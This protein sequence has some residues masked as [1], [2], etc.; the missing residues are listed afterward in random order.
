MDRANI[1]H[2]NFLARVAARDLP[3][4]RPPAGPMAPE[5]ALQ[6]FRAGVLTRALD[7][8]SRAMQRAGPVSYTHLEVYKRQVWLFGLHAV[9]DALLN[10][11]REKLRLVVTRNALDKLE[12]AVAFAGIA[13]ELADPRK[14]DVPIDEGSVHQL[15]LIHI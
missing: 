5:T 10:P 6:A 13:P 15:S 14:F 2:E 8:Q 7:R 4:G 9:R 3:A 12:E 1:V 11:A